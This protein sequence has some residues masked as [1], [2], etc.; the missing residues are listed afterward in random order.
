MFAHVVCR[1]TFDT[2]CIGASLALMQWC[3]LGCTKVDNRDMF[4][5]AVAVYENL[6][7]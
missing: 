2:L 1:F 6:N 3:G 7:D 4:S 5:E